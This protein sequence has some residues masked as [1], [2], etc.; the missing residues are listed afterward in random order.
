MEWGV[1]ARLPVISQMSDDI[2]IQAELDYCQ[3]WL[4]GGWYSDYTV[5]AVLHRYNS[6]HYS[7][8]SGKRGK[9]ETTADAGAVAK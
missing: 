4:V 6:R 7:L 8:D 1:P 5:S 2:H 3:P 9:K